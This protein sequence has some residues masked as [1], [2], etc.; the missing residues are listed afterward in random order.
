MIDLLTIVLISV[1]VGSLAVHV[2]V[3]GWLID[4]YIIDFIMRLLKK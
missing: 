1:F 2:Y 3:I 4:T